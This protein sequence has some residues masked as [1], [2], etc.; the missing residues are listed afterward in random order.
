MMWSDG[1]KE[2][3]KCGSV[4]DRTEK[5]VVTLVIVGTD[6]AEDKLH[7]S[8]QNMYA[9]FLFKGHCNR[10]KSS[11]LALFPLSFLDANTL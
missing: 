2:S 7:R 8:N 3:T 11:S 1:G 6:P 4:W 10:E 9:A 5:V